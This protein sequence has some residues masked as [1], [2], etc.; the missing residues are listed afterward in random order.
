M[1]YLDPNASPNRWSESDAVAPLPNNFTSRNMVG[2]GGKIYALGNPAGNT[3]LL[4]VYDPDT[5]SW[6]LAE[7]FRRLI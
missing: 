5:N 4:L 2:L 7:D 1:F 3:T 6:S